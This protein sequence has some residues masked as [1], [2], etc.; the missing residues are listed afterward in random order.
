MAEPLQSLGSSAD[1]FSIFLVDD[2]PANCLALRT[3][4]QGRDL[5]FVEAPSSED[6]L[7]QKIPEAICRRL[8][9]WPGPFRRLD[10]QRLAV[11]QTGVRIARSKRS[12]VKA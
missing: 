8:I 11:I 7:A 3:I 5:N 1:K 9:E 10:V 6:A 4:V 2:E 12:G